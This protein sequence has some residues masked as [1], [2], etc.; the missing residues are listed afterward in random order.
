MGYAIIFVTYLV[1]VLV[2]LTRTGP[3]GSDGA[4]KVHL[5]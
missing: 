3:V 2:S 1:V 5:P 4:V